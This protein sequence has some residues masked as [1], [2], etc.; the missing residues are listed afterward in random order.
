MPSPREQPPP[1]RSRRRQDTMPG[2]WL[3]V[4]ILCLLATVMYFTLG[5]NNAGILDYSEFMKLAK[6][7]KFAKVTIKGSTR[8]VGEFKPGEADKIDND[9]VKKQIRYNKIETNIP[10]A[11]IQS[12]N[13]TRQLTEFGVPYRTEEETGAWI[14]PLFMFLLPTLLLVGFFVFFLLPRFRDPLGGGFLSNYVKSPAK[15]YDKTKMRVT[16]EDV[17]NM[18]AAKSEL[19]E[20]VDFLKSPEKFQRSAPDPQGRVARRPARHRQDLARACGGRRGGRPVLLDQR[21]RVHSNVRRRGRQPGTR[22]V[23]HG[24]GKLPLPVVHRRD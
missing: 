19:Q 24:Q 13:V 18:I 9:N 11:E 17:A 20:I 15:R 2:G 10:A 7:D 6:K 16:F 23:P 3:W 5:F 22:Y 21:L 14:G 1:N 12:G 8:M 4:A